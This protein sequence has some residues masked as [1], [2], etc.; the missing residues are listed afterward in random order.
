MAKENAGGGGMVTV[1]LLGA[2]AYLAYEYFFGS[3]TAT[4]VPVAPTTTPPNPTTT[5]T[6]SGSGTTVA[7]S[8]PITTTTTQTT[9][10]P[11]SSGTL[12][13]MYKSLVAK[14]QAS[15]GG[16]P[17]LSGSGDSIL[18]SG[19]SPWSVLNYYLAAVSGYTNLPDYQG[20]TGNTDPN[21]PITVQAYWALIS[22][23]LTSNKGLSGIQ[24]IMRGL[25]AV[26]QQTRRRA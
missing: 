8:T 17:V 4:T 24:G 5:T 13:A 26:L 12:A 9:T 6:T 2:A 11:V 22:P 18:A 16:D 20:A 23:W 3:T 14:L 21:T 1:L 7:S 15:V 19:P 10:T 25:G